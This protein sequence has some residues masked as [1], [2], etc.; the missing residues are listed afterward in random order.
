M[1]NLKR[2]KIVMLGVVPIIFVLLCAH[3]YLRGGRFVETDNAYIRTDI[4]PISAEVSGLIE[5]LAVRENQRVSKGD[6]LFYVNPKPFLVAVAKSEAN[7]GEVKAHLES[8]KSSYEEKQAGIVLAE[9]NFL[10]AQKELQR[11]IDLQGKNFVSASVLD[12]L[13]HS[14]ETA[15]QQIKVLDLDLQTILASL[16]GD[17]DA[18]LSEHPSFKGALAELHVAELDLKHTEVEAPSSGIVSNV[19]TLG[20]YVREG[21][22]MLAL[23]SNSYFWV[24]ANF[25]EKDLT[26]LQI[27]Q[28]VTIKIDTYPG[29]KWQGLVE[30]ISPA[31]GAE[32]AILPPQNA[33]GN[34]VKVAQRVPVRI[35]IL[36]GT[37]LPM[38]RSGLSAVVTVDTN[39]QRELF[40]LR[41]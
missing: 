28:Q 34:W 37:A 41:W 39:K 10:F 32:F 4:I 7:L 30:S 29:V 16:G 24:E 40:G 5:T 11:Q 26:H 23:V 35:Q 38:L 1:N 8:L 3:F 36:E 19:P 27:E 18:P 15:E 9:K 20:Q 33:T 2:K 25:T 22:M 13:R 31:T 12:N 17:I 21:N 6:I 14:V